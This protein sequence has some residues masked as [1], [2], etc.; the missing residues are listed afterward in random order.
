MPSWLWLLLC[1][2]AH[3]ILSHGG[4]KEQAM[5]LFLG[6]MGV[7]ISIWACAVSFPFKQPTPKVE[8][9]SVLLVQVVV[10]FFILEGEALQAITSPLAILWWLL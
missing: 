7:W 8:L 6:S 3:T 2:A 10:C 9:L 4:E 1:T 5:Y